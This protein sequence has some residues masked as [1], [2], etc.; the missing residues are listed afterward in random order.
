MITPLDVLS[1]GLTK[2]Y[3]EIEQ[4]ELPEDKRIVPVKFNPTEYQLQ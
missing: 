1:Q 3:L 2:A 4:P